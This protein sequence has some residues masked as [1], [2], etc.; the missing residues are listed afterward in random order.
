MTIALLAAAAL[1]CALLTANALERRA[2]NQHTAALI[3][4]QAETVQAFIAQVDRLC[5]RL[6]APQQAVIDHTIQ[7]LQPGPPPIPMDDDAGYDDLHGLSK[8]ELAELV[9]D[10][11][12][13]T[14]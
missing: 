14:S 2:H 10:A 12:L 11:E 13:R 3:T 7:T 8:D 5:Q 9:A 6:Q 4:N 1:A